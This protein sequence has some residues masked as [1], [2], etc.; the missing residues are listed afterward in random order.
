M[1]SLWRLVLLLV[2]VGSSAVP[3]E[4]RFDGADGFGVPVTKGPIYTTL[5]SDDGSGPTV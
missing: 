2:L 1:R 5:V 3:G 4:A